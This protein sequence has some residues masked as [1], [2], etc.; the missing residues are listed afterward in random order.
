MISFIK[1]CTHIFNRLLPFPQL[2]VLHQ[3]TKQTTSVSF[4]RFYNL[5]WVLVARFCPAIVVK[6]Y[7]CRIVSVS[8]ITIWFNDYSFGGGKIANCRFPDIAVPDLHLVNVEFSYPAFFTLSI[9]ARRVKMVCLL[10]PNS[11]DSS[12][13]FE[14]GS[15]RSVTFCFSLSTFVSDRH[16]YFLWG[17][18][19][20]NEILQTIFYTLCNKIKMK[21]SI[22]IP[23]CLFLQLFQERTVRNSDLSFSKKE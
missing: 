20:H 1:V 8:H 13:T 11:D 5:D 21:H 15:D 23:S 6:I 7:G 18:S 12:L 4:D 19:Y 10:T 16:R 17:Q 22:N 14:D 3:I 9:S 2:L